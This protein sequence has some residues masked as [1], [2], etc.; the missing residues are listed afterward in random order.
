[1]RGSGGAPASGGTERAG[2]GAWTGQEL[3]GAAKATDRPPPIP[4]GWDYTYV[5]SFYHCALAMG[6][7][8]LLPKVNKKAGSAGPP[9]RL[10]CP[11]LCC[12]CV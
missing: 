7:V 5:H 8:L 6:L 12:T 2:T 11:T 3:R 9:A 10:D 4:Q 1:M